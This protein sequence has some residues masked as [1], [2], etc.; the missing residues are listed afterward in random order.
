LGTTGLGT[1]DLGTS[2]E[3]LATRSQTEFIK[4]LLFEMLTAE[5]EFV[6]TALK[7]ELLLF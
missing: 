3:G 7:E 2:S 4:E 1:T 5:L 6:L